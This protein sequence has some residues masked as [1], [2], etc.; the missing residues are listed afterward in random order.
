MWIPQAFGC[1][2]G[3]GAAAGLGAGAG[4]C[5]GA[6]AGVAFATAGE[7]VGTAAGEAG[8][9]ARAAGSSSS[10]SSSPYSLEASSGQTQEILEDLWS[11]SIRSY[12]EKNWRENQLAPLSW[13]HIIYHINLFLYTYKHTQYIYIY[14]NLYFEYEHFVKPDTTHLPLAQSQALLQ[15]AVPLEQR[16]VQV[17]P[18]PVQ[19]LL[20]L[21]GQELANPPPQ[22]HPP[23]SFQ[24]SATAA[25]RF[26]PPLKFLSD[27]T[28]DISKGLAANQKLCVQL[29]WRIQVYQGTLLVGG[30]NPSEKCYI[31]KLDHFPRWGWK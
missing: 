28:D 6:G 16:P 8:C 13:F 29:K 25:R 4:A 15:V 23:H 22:T 24:A 11:M 14:L 20:P 26:Q 9:A 1:T 19:V 27:M 7:A 30:F 5:T 10:K 3:A 31:V 12:I 2:T 17:L 18:L 21:L